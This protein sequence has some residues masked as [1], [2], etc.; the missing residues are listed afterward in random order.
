MA[1]H[2]TSGG[3]EALGNLEAGKNAT[4]LR[5]KGSELPWNIDVI[6]M[7]QLLC[8]GVR[9]APVSGLRSVRSALGNQT[10]AGDRDRRGAEARAVI[11]V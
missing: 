3:E 1:V 4:A 7:K 8:C 9:S 11:T 5:G 2:Q 10:F 6:A